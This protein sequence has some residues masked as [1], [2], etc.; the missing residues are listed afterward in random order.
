MIVLGIDASTQTAGVA[1]VNNE[2]LMGEITI[3]TT[4][5][6]SEKLM[7]IVDQLFSNLNLKLDDIDGIAVT[8]GPGSFTGVR[9]G[10]AT[11]LGLAKAKNI[12]LAGIS[13][14]EGLAYNNKNYRGIICPIQDARRNQIY[15]GFFK[16]EGDNLVRLSPDMAISIAEFVEK[17][18]TYEE[19]I[20]LAGPDANKFIEEIKLKCDREVTV[21]PFN[22][23]LPRA[24]SIAYLS[25]TKEFGKNI[26]PN[27][28]RK[29]QAE[30]SY[31]EIHGKS[32]Y[33]E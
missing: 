28:V 26:T 24:S 27:Y 31:E 6:H 7:V 11:A 2:M 23:S 20:L 5:T 19:D 16:F 1:I 30:T 12:S 25:M 32:V 18:N 14:I 22:L 13:T 15:T 9:I 17:A 29:S 8:I 21:S 4:I 33:D 3:N 10:M